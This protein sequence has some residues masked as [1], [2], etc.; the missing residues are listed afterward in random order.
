GAVVSKMLKIFGVIEKCLGP[1][2]FQL[3]PNF[4]KDV[5][6]LDAFLALFPARRRVAFE[7]RHASWFDEEVFGVLRDHRAAMCIAEADEALNVP[8]VSTADF[9]YVRLRRAEYSDAELK[10]WIKRI[11]R[12]DW[13]DAFIFFKH[14]DKGKGPEFAARFL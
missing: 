12:Q 9:G 4:K 6:R 14:E 1:I 3:P 11:R 7:F 13:R 2:L 10:T 8:F 5:P